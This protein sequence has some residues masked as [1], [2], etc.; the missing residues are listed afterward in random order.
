[1]PRWKLAIWHSLIARAVWRR[2]HHKANGRF[3]T[4]ERPVTVTLIARYGVVSGPSSEAAGPSIRVRRCAPGFGG[5]GEVG[6]GRIVVRAP[7]RGEPVALGRGSTRV[8]PVRVCDSLDVPRG[9]VIREAEQA[10]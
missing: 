7:A 2:R 9:E 6:I 1:M 4:R 5:Y 10:E 8:N 3:H